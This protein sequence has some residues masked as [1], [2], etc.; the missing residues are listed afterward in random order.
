MSVPRGLQA[1][2]V[3]CASMRRWI[4]AIFALHFLLSVGLLAL[5]PALSPAS[6]PALG[7]HLSFG[8]ASGLQPTAEPV[9]SILSDPAGEPLTA[10]AE[11][12][13]VMNLTPDHALADAQPELPELLALDTSAFDMP[14]ALLSPPTAFRPGGPSPTLQGPQRPPPAGA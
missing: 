9:A 2:R 6:G 4:V 7:N 12:Q 13:R 1:Q 11:I 5:G 8:Q 3:Q 14:Q 10:Q